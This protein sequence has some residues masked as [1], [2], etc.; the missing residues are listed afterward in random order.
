MNGWNFSYVDQ[1]PVFTQGELLEKIKAAAPVLA[2]AVEGEGR[3][4]D[5]LGWFSGNSCASLKQVDVWRQLALKIKPDMDAFV[6]I[7]IGGSNQAARAAVTALCPPG[8]DKIVWAGNTLSAFELERTLKFLDT[9]KSIYLNC[10]AK[11]FETL[12]PGITFRVLRNYLEKRYGRKAAAD[13]IFATGTFGSSLDRFCQEEG[14]TFLEF[15][16]PVGGR[17]SIG[18]AV[19]L[20][21]MAVAGIDITA[22]TE[23]MRTMQKYLWSCPAEENPAL[24][25]ACLRNLCYEHG[26]RIEML[27]FFEP[28]LRYLAKWWIQLFAESE[29]KENKGLYPVASCN[30]EDL[31]ATGQFVQQGT[32]VI[33]ETFLEIAS[34]DA[35]VLVPEDE[36]IDHFAY[37]AGKDFWDINKIA[38]EATFRAHADRGIPCLN[39]RL[40]ALDAYN[41][42]ALFYFFMFSCYLDGE[43]MGINPFNEPGVDAYKHYMFKN[44]GKRGY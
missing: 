14:Y 11:N 25:Y 16:V 8:A 39:L 33:F 27:A 1:K 17:Y 40:P 6:D 22:L 19:G 34:Q 9:K 4:A 13:H 32:P 44:L 12:E 36:R 7:G 24:K 26:Y 20:F 5:K 38:R 42:G 30:S 18:T 28:R 3:Y 10:I 41:L 29:G 21:P 37:V 15:P 31:H 2:G 43:I 35:S 23:G